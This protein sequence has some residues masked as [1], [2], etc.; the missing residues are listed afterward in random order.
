MTVKEKRLLQQH[1]YNAVSWAV[2]L[3]HQ[4]TLM[5]RIFTSKRHMIREIPR[6]LLS[7]WHTTTVN[8]VQH[9]L[10]NKCYKMLQLVE[11]QSCDL[12]NDFKNT[13][14]FCW[15]RIDGEFGNG[16]WRKVVVIVRC[17]RCWSNPETLPGKEKQTQYL[18]SRMAQQQNI[19]WAY[20][21]P[22]AELK[23]FDVSSYRN[24]I[25]MDATSFKDLQ[26][27]APLMTYQKNHM[28]STIPGNFLQ[29]SI[30]WHMHMVS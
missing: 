17:K 28:R 16:E 25:R 10:L 13:F 11:W 18:H 9:L 7:R 22:M 4:Q 30:N 26:L 5:T 24:F 14:S 19:V 8:M 21:S 29:H 27:V 6:V 15:T 2:T 3:T 12:L 20:Y 23:N 1:L